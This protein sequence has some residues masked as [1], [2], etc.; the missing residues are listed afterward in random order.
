MQKKPICL[1]AARG[2]SKGVPGKNIR[3]LGNKPLIAHTI[4]SAINS[5]LFSNVIVTTEDKKIAKI[6]KRYGADVPFIRPKK[7]ASDKIDY[8]KV[9]T[10]AITNLKSLGYDFDILVNRDCTVPFI[11]NSD[12]KKSIKLLRKENCDLVCGVYRQHHNPYFNMMELDSNGYLK[13]SKKMKNRSL[14][15]QKSPI[16]YQLNGLFVI[17]VK[18][19]LKY[20]KTYMPKTMPIEISPESGHMIDTEFEFQIA[21]CVAKKIIKL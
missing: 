4:K 3:K 16:V 20:G 5:G 17:N 19:Y 21:D 18:Q 6:A 13:F 10:H 15:R 11:K 7:L 2:G 14:G 9:I 12:V 8:E 1:I